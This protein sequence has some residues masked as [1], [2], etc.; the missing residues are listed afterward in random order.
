V[1]A[2]PTITLNGR[3]YPLESPTTVPDLLATLGF[4]GKPVVVELNGQALTPAE[5]A[6]AQVT[7][8]ATLELITL[9]AGG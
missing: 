6:T 9:A 1:T 2:S 7:P 4:A 8:G 3:P 5:H